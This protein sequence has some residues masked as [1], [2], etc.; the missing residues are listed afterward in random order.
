METVSDKKACLIKKKN[1]KKVT[2][3]LLLQSNQIQILV[4]VV[5]CPKVFQRVCVKSCYFEHHFKVILQNKQTKQVHWNYEKQ[6][7]KK[8]NPLR[9]ITD[10]NIVDETLEVFIV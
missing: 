7:I 6:V 2:L 9:V 5:K 8:K 1:N 3:L 4:L 10:L